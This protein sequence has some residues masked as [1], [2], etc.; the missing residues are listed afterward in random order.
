MQKC[1]NCG[2]ENIDDESKFCNKCGSYIKLSN[3]EIQF[4]KE[5]HDKIKLL[6]KTLIEGIKLIGNEIKGNRSKSFDILLYRDLIFY[7]LIETTNIED[8]LH[9]LSADNFFNQLLTLLKTLKY[10]D[11]Y[12]LNEFLVSINEIY[13]QTK[14]ENKSEIKFIFYTNIKLRDSQKEKFEEL[15]DFFGLKIFNYKDYNFQEENFDFEIFDSNYLLLSCTTKGKDYSFMYTTAKNMVYAFFGYLTYLA[16]SFRTLERYNVNQFS[17]SHNIADLYISSVIE[18]DLSNI[19]IDYE[20]SHNVI[21]ASKTFKKSKLPKFNNNFISHDF[22]KCFADSDNNLIVKKILEYFSFYYLATIEGDLNQSAIKFWTLSEKI[23]KDI[24]SEMADDKLMKYMQK[25]LKL[26]KYPKYIQNRI[27]HI[28][29]KRNKFI[30]ENIGEFNQNDRNI[31]KLV[32]DNLI[33]FVIELN[34]VVKNMQE[35][36]TILDYFNQDNKRT[37]ELLNY[38]DENIKK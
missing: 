14:N 6:E 37:I 9:L 21:G 18:L 20:F 15:L 16:N 4:K 28:K 17:L 32:A 13:D 36:K 30:H 19:F 7:Y 8:K 26:Y 23:I 24:G 3:K 27:P 34:E 2:N 38:I 5:K 10:D 33:I 22:Y 35:Y 11:K 12:I 25:I 29:D 31:I 1:K